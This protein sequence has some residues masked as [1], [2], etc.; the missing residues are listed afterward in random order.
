MGEQ[1]K[2]RKEKP[3]RW[4]SRSREDLRRFPDD[5]RRDIG[6]ALDFAQRGAKHPSAKPLKG[7]GGAGVLEVVEDH[8]G[9]TYRAVYT[10]RFAEIVY[11]LHAFMKKST[12][13]IKTPKHEIDLIE[14]RL[15]AAEAD[16]KGWRKEKRN[17]G[18][19]HEDQSP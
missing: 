12:S 14:Q 18:A 16:Y 17:E 6:F 13:G 10:V 5:V 2:Q 11:V 9:D 19:T 3:I 4:V 1:R 8:R 15:K 7:F